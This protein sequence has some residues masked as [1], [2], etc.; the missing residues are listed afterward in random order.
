MGM[1]N[2][3]HVGCGKADKPA[4][5]AGYR[6]TRVDCDPTVKPDVVASIAA[7]PMIE[8]ESQD[9]VHCSHCLEHLHAHEVAMALGEFHRVLKPGG[10]VEIFVPDLQ[11]IGGR[12]ALDQLDVPLYLSGF[13]PIS[14]LDMLYGHRGSIAAGQSFMQHRTG[15]TASVLKKAL[16]QAGFRKVLTERVLT[17]G[18]PE[19]K[20]IALKE[21]QPTVH[22]EEHNGASQ[23]RGPAP[24]SER[25]QGACVGQEAPL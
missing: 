25:D 19:L 8:A 17:A 20:G 3:L 1:K 24:L 6:E 10:M 13:G 7:M 11:G 12:I 22:L 15:F 2:L 23:E 21:E 9:T 4:G 14:P 18:C 5:F 16:E